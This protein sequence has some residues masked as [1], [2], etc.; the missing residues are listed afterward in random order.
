VLLA[1]RPVA[2][3]AHVMRHRAP[4]Q[5][6][7]PRTHERWSAV[8]DDV[9]PRDGGPVVHESEP[10]LIEQR[11]LGVHDEVRIE[12]W[13]PEAHRHVRRREDEPDAAAA[14][15]GEVEFDHHAPRRQRLASDALMD[16]PE[17]QHR[18]EFL[19]PGRAERPLDAPRAEPVEDAAQVEPRLGEQV[20]T[21]VRPLATRS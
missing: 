7:G 13:R 11:E 18:V 1:V 10:H 9:P 12:S 5:P 17:Q 2:R 19:A 20:L 6:A 21:H 14:A 8:N 4:H 15:S 16:L 3:G